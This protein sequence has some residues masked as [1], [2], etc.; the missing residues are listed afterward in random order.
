MY[1]Q[2]KGDGKG[3]W[4][5]HDCFGDPERNAVNGIN[6]IIRLIK[7]GVYNME[8]CRIWDIYG[9]AIFRKMDP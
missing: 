2:L 7:E 3:Y 1:P 5:A 4:I 9:L 8:Y 6:E